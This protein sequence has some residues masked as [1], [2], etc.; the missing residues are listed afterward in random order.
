MRKLKYMCICCGEILDIE[1]KEGNGKYNYTDENFKED[2]EVGENIENVSYTVEKPKLYILAKC[3]NCGYF[4]EAVGIDD[5]IADI[6]SKMN[7]KGYYTQFSCQGH[8]KDKENYTKAYIIFKTSRIAD[9]IFFI[10]R[11]YRNFPSQAFTI[12]RKYSIKKGES[13][14]AIYM[15]N[16]YARNDDKRKEALRFLEEFVDNLPD[17]KNVH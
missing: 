3:K 15:R 11:I 10:N 14:I 7:K 5:E 8:I 12:N 17:I 9:D 6:V 4:G 13:A 16:N 2:Y 1:Q